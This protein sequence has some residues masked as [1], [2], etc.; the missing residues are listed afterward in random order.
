MVKRKVFIS[1]FPVLWKAFEDS[2]RR[3]LRHQQQP[4]SANPKASNVT[5]PGSGIHCSDVP[6]SKPVNP[7]VVVMGVGFAV[8]EAAPVI[9]NGGD[10]PT[11]PPGLFRAS[12]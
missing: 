6:I 11:N 2:V 4:S 10:S 7:P 8:V 1:K 5:V 12:S 3:V 9:L